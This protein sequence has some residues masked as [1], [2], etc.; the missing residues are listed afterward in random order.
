MLD[1]Y[2]QQRDAILKF[3]K[4][5]AFYQ[6]RDEEDYKNIR[7]LCLEGPPGVGKTKLIESLC[8][9]YGINLV[10][11]K[12]KNTVGEYGW[13]RTFYDD[14]QPSKAHP[15]VQAMYKSRKLGFDGYTMVFFDE[16]DKLPHGQD[17]NSNYLP[18]LE[19]VAQLL[20]E[21]MDNDRETI[22]DGYSGMDFPK[23]KILL[24]IA[25]NES[26]LDRIPGL[27]RRVDVIK[28]D[29]IKPEIKQEIALRKLHSFCEDNKLAI[30]DDLINTV[31]SMTNNNQQDGVGEL[32]EEIRSLVYELSQNDFYTDTVLAD[33]KKAILTRYESTLAEPAPEQDSKPGPRLDPH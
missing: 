2:P 23:N 1:T 32:I 5:V 21:I 27:E 28:F 11:L 22:R 31:T 18:T 4:S 14:L 13:E 9:I 33:D 30:N 16:I 3:A 24:A 29:K 15:L 7:A 20:L 6:L 25:V 10:I 8:E 17:A 26:I 12:G 19:E